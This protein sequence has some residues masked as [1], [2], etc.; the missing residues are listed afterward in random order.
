MKLIAAISNK[1][2]G[3][4]YVEENHTV[5]RASQLI[6]GKEKPA[7][8]LKE[9]GYKARFPDAKITPKGILRGRLHFAYE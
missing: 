1:Y 6:F 4:K 7:N 9:K 2:G 5:V 8:V 3:K